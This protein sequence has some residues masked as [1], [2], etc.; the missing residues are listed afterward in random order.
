MWVAVEL[1]LKDWQKVIELLRENCDSGERSDYGNTLRR[2]AGEGL[3]DKIE[4]GVSR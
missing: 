4:K 2:E 3:A 1:T